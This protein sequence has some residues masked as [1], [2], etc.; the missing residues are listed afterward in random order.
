MELVLN[1]FFAEIIRFIP[2]IKV[3]DIIDVLVVSFI[4]YQAFKLIKE[5]RA[6]QLIKGIL[7]LVFLLYFSS[8]LQLYTLKYILEHT[9]QL[10]FLALLVVFQPELRRA[11]E[12]VGRSPISKLFKI[13]EDESEGVKII[14]EIARAVEAMSKNKIGALIVIERDTGLGEIIESGT[15]IDGS[16]SAELLVNIFVPNT[17]LHDGAVIIRGAKIV[18]AACFLP[19]TH[20]TDLSKE[21]GTRH[22]AAL[23]VSE[24][25][26]S[27]AI[28]VSEETGRISLAV[29]GNLARNLTV[30]SLKK[31][32]NKALRPTNK[33][34]YKNKLLFWR[35]EKK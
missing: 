25:S 2:T 34:E 15:K 21:L 17:P 10:G 4:I 28:I 24:N 31:A 6:E 5:T 33:S 19:L 20:N 16:I 9:M 7:V 14:S 1:N 30:D 29:N 18:S 27:L 11:L 35:G 3:N 13:G 12:Q 23:G 22:R 32:L 8:W 26:D